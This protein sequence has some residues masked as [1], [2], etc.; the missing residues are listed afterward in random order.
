MGAGLCLLLSPMTS[1]QQTT[2]TGATGVL[3]TPDALIAAS[4]ALN[5]QYNNLLESRFEPDNTQ[6]RNHVFA[7]GI[8][9]RFE[10]G[11]RLTDFTPI[12]DRVSVRGT[13]NGKR[14]LS[15]NAKANLYNYD[16]RFWLSVGAL[17]FGGLAQNFNSRYGVGTLRWKQLW[18]SAGFAAGDNE[19]F[20]GGFTNLHFKLNPYLSLMTE[21]D[22]DGAVNAGLTANVPLGNKLDLGTTISSSEDEVRVGLNVSY[23]LGSSHGYREALAKA[24]EVSIGKDSQLSKTDKAAKPTLALSSLEK[25]LAEIGFANTRVG[26]ADDGSYVVQIENN[27][28]VHS[29]QDA[30]DR[31]LQLSREHLPGNTDV[32]IGLLRHGLVKYRMRFSADIDKPDSVIDQLAPSLASNTIWN[33][34]QY[35]SGRQLA[36]FT[37]QPELRSAVGTELG[38]IDYTLGVRT[39]V[40]VPLWQGASAVVAGIVPLVNSTNY[41]DGNPFAANRLDLSLERAMLVQYLPI[42]GTAHAQVEL[43]EVQVRNFFYTGVKTQAAWQSSAWPMLVHASAAQYRLKESS[44]Q[45]NVFLGTAA[46]T[47]PRYHASLSATYGQFF[48]GEHG[49]KLNGTRRFGNTFASVFLKIISSDDLAG[50]LQIS[51]PIGP[52][53]SFSWRG[54]T[55]S[56]ASRWSHGLQTTIKF[57]DASDNRIQPGFLIEPLTN[58]E[59]PQAILD[60]GRLNPFDVSR[61]Y[62]SGPSL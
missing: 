1:A 14:D 5:Y 47:L 45:R 12:G 52:K 16:N 36:T 54:L 15:G 40:T 43:G 57:P 18:V 24:S 58:S 6:G 2:Y 39:G 53:K 23:R 42:G 51:A 10:L 62:R 8:Y 29:D 44:R 26:N 34:S 3:S 27:V 32:E 48:F 49:V 50:G 17:D 61:H 33:I 31:V 59:I 46:Y 41:D 38:T 11:G 55:F 21:L 4:G 22:T 13:L 19:S 37:V 25:A 56:G 30:M 20:D 35:A 28:Y 7:L 9:P 60:S